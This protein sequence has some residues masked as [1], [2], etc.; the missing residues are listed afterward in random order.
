[1]SLEELTTKEKKSKTKQARELALKYKDLTYNQ[2]RAKIMEKI[3]C[4][5]STATKGLKWFERQL[6]QEKA[7]KP[8]FEVAA[9]AQ[10]TPEFMEKPEEIEEITAPSE[11]TEITPEEVE[12]QLDLFRDMMRG[13]HVILF[14]KDGLVDI[15]IKGGV[16]E[17]QAKRV[18]DQA[19][20]WLL[21]RYSIEELE[22]WDTI[23]LVASY[24]TLVGTIA[25]N[26][27]KHREKTKTKKEEKKK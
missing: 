19:Y 20:R 4:S 14:A 10:K 17:T 27:L 6:K 8:R 18:S 9:E 26:A 3:P 25:R 22:K 5:R 12:E 15:L 1:M 11:I 21:R 13:L 24:G 23:F 7:A 2:A 16:E